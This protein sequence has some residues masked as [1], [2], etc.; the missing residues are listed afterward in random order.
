MR[1]QRWLGASAALVTLTLVLAACSSGASPSASAAGSS[2][3]A[4]ASVP[5]TAHSD[6]KIGVVTDVGTA[7]DKNFNEYTY[8]GTKQGAAAIGAAEPPVTVPKD[9]SEFASSIQAY[10]DD[11]YD[12]I[13]TAGFS[14]GVATTQAA[15]DNP[16]VWFIGV[17]QGPPCVN[18]EGLPDTTFACA[19]DA[20]TLLPHF[21][22]LSYQ[23]DQAGYLAGMA[24][25]SAS[26]SGTIGAILGISL[27]G[28]CIRYTQGFKLGAESIN[29]DIKLVVNWVTE[30]DFVKAFNDP[31][32]G[33]S[34]GDQFL[35]Q[36][37]DV[38][39]L[40]QVAGKTGNGVLDAAC[41]AGIYG[42]GVD[43]DQSLSY[44]NA[45]KCTITS[46]MKSLALAVSTDIGK[47]VDGS[48]KGGDDHWDASR[49]GIAYGPFHD[50]ASAFPAN[51]ADLLDA[52]FAKM[53]AGTL[54]TCPEKCGDLS[55]LK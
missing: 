3:S 21:V 18:A 52:A 14:L 53:K 37:P 55:T 5:V 1:K 46:A 47:I 26:K 22:A 31:V 45:A 33:K 6:L 51:M 19:G 32:S 54:V 41:E 7:N 25:A 42:I 34:Y 27:C 43:V 11:G 15:H 20:A 9:S 4:P 23:E 12:I 50:L 2:E 49:D 29:P 24:A 30:S 38:D 17:D 13:V 48:M 28:P 39:V 8:V 10:V 35:Q 36:N 16:D 44:P 40:F